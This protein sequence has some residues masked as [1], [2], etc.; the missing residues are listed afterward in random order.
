[1]VRAVLEIHDKVIFCRACNL[2]KFK[3]K[4]ASSIRTRYFA[5]LNGKKSI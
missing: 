3:K 2:G 4:V 1:M 5:R